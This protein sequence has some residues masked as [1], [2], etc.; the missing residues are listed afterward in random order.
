[1]SDGFDAGRLR[2]WL[3]D[4]VAQRAG[5]DPADVDADRTFVEYGLTSR[6]GVALSGEL[7]DLLDR[8]LPAT[9]VW[10][11]PTITALV[12]RLTPGTERAEIIENPVAVPGSEPIAVVGVGCRLPGGVAGPGDFWRLLLDG[13]DA[14]GRVPGERWTSF[15]DG[16]P[17]TAAVLERTTRWGGYLD[18]VAGFDADFFGISPR[19]AAAMDPQQRL[20]LEVGWEALEHAGLAPE[21]L[22]GSATGVFVGVS[23]GEYGHLTAADLA[24][25]EAWTGTGAAM[26][27]IAGRLSYLLDLRGPSLVVD[28]ACSSSL[29]AVHQAVQSLR[30]GES[31]TALAGGVNALLSPAVTVNFDRAGAMAADGRCKTFAA[32]ADGYVR[33]EGCGVV[34]LKRLADARRDGDRVL[35]VLR[36]SAVNSDGRSNGLMAPRAQAQAAVLR[37]ACSAAG[38]D[39]REVDY[40]EAHGTGTPLG[41]PIEAAAL[42]TV[43]GRGRAPDRPLLVGSVKTNVGH[44]E[45]AAG[46]TGLIKVV[47]GLAYRRIPASLHFR[48]PSPRIDFAENGLRVVTETSPWPR[49]G[50]PARAGVSSFGFGGTNAHVVVEEAPPPVERSGAVAEPAVR[51]YPLSGPTPERVAAAAGSLARWLDADD[52][53]APLPALA[54][55]LDRRFPAGRA[56]AAVVARS[57]EELLDGLRALSAGERT[58]GVVTGVAGPAERGLV[59]IF[60][61]QGSQWAGMGRRLLADEPDFADAVADLDPLLAAEAGFS[62]LDVLTSG[63][64]LAGSDRI[65]PVLFGMQVALAALWRSHGVEPDAVIGHSMGEVAAAVVSGALSAEDGV[66]VIARRSRLAGG[67]AG[68]GAMAVVELASER[69]GELL[70][71]F[72]G[73][74]LAVSNAPRQ[75]VVAGDVAAVRDL[76]AH[77]E[78]LDLLARFVKV[79]YA[80][81]SAQVDPLLGELA[82]LLAEVRG[83]Q[84]ETGFYS[85]VLDDPAVPPAF[86]AA[87]WAANLRRPVRFRQAVEAALADGHSEFVEISP[88]P[89]LTHAVTETLAE[90]GAGDAAVLATLRRD[91]DETRVFHANL[92]GLALRGRPRPDTAPQIIDLPTT[93]WRHE[94]HWARTGRARVAHSGAPSADTLLGTHQR[95]GTSPESDVWQTRLVPEALPYPGSH[96]LHGAA[97]VPASVLVNTALAAAARTDR[98]AAVNLRLVR[99]L[100]PDRERE[101]QVVAHGPALRISSRSGPDAPWTLHLTAD[102]SASAKAPVADAAPPPVRGTTLTQDDIDRLFADRGVV[103]SGYPWRVTALTRRDGE[104]VG[105][106]EP[107]RDPAGH[108][109][110]LDLALQ[111]APLA[112]ARGE[113]AEA[114]HVPARLGEVR[115]HGTPAGPVTLHVRQADAE[116]P[117]ET[118]M[119]ITVTGRDGGELLRV[120]RATY[121]LLGEGAP[122]APERDATRLSYEL[123]WHPVEPPPA[124]ADRTVALVG[125]DSPLAQLLASALAE[126]GH[127]VRRAGPD[128]GVGDADAVVVLP[129]DL[130][131]AASVAEGA[132]RLCG[133][134]LTTLRGLLAEARTGAALW[135]V[136]S[137]VRESADERA[138]AQ[139]PLWGLARVLA[140]EHP[141]LAGGVVD[142]EAGQPL[143]EAASTLAA[144]VAGEPVDLVA[145]RGGERLVPR[146]IAAGSAPSRPEPRCRPDA[147]YLVTGG[148]GDLGLEVARWLA[149]RGARRLLLAGRT[150]LPPR[151]EW[152]EVADRRQRR[153]I[154]AV[155]ELESAG[156]VV[157]MV[158]LDVGDAGAL[159]EFVGRR[160]RDGLPPIA[161]VVHAAGVIDDRVLEEIDADSLAAVLRPKVAGSWALHEVFPPG[162]LDFLVLFSSAGAWFGVPG[163][164]GYAAGNAFLDAL[165]RSR[166]LAGDHTVSI[167]WGAWDGLGFAASG[168][169]RLVT[170][171]L[172]RLGLRA[173]HV[174]EARTAWEHLHMRDVANALV[175][176]TTG[177]EPG[178]DLPR[179]LRDLVQGGESPRPESE[180]GVS[181]ASLTPSERRE[182]LNALVAEELGMAA[183]A[184]DPNRPL[185][186]LGLDSIMALSIR[187]K[188]ERGAGLR[189]PVT[190]LWNHPTAEALAAYLDERL[191]ER[192]AEPQA[193]D[194]A[195]RGILDDLLSDIE[196]AP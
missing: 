19:E 114:L 141:E 61:G 130:D 50:R 177:A 182:R 174:D 5:I 181:W 18:D 24:E 62:L 150:P 146:L 20:L 10:D 148:L 23:A 92:A 143:R 74:E 166:S 188:A 98:R 113:D 155:R 125:P 100:T 167:G 26:S 14:I 9:V 87:Y 126:A 165:A 37:S 180:A 95:I 119:E 7:E 6:D 159:R 129:P 59:W 55:T 110:L 29:V 28:T 96:A 186:E 160:D 22:R 73:V 53:A 139:A 144:I 152:D 44:L 106:V 97:V 51:R 142:L 122:S 111:L 8:T 83:G 15:D 78:G 124:L 194:D 41:D 11:C 57:R 140:A 175:V 190:A 121:V 179:L 158:R 42:G 85:T 47:L 134:T 99:P 94:R 31:D 117:G 27:V 123:A 127:R 63:E 156:V 176:P 33:G 93:P 173:L 104:L 82:D 149:G 25:V 120:A 172:R 21:R 163:Q 38:V 86:D 69:V 32:D 75:S 35:A 135:L 49:A 39:P 183:G 17:E 162:E 66:K 105:S 102:L 88:H 136:T 131:P 189:I 12:E 116:A 145:P 64:E 138:L 16:S 132:E 128:H 171:T 103:G 54:S 192:P 191:D 34:V 108:A 107:V 168:G 161:G 45:A 109:D 84:P 89:V 154:T 30:S 65:Q 137:G 4:R 71:R 70:P 43:L 195:P 2:R 36:G 169:G 115:A 91:D 112:A 185:A 101:V 80:S 157:H 178:A 67:L 13:G 170:A 60:P 48:E 196:S 133:T 184:L 90:A 164:G 77:V 72:P 58:P 68:R 151:R 81:H 3:T 46:V 79:D 147:A 118:V 52:V 56:R 153:Q 193:E 1:M 40:V 187:T 76:V